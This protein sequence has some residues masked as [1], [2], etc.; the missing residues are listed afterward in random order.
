MLILCL[1]QSNV[2]AASLTT[3]NAWTEQTGMKE[4]LEGEDLSEELK[5]ENP[6]LRQEVRIIPHINYFYEF[7]KTSSSHVP[8]SSFL[9]TPFSNYIG[10]SLLS[11]C[12]C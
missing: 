5:K 2:R 1:H 7:V 6:F 4:W 3:V 11:F 12:S 8:F 10:P 9:L